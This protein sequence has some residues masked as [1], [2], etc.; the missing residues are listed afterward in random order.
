M[1]SGGYRAGAGR[2]KGTGPWGEKTKLMRIPVSLVGFVN[3][4]LATQELCLPYIALLTF[5]KSKASKNKVGQRDD[6][7]PLLVD[8]DGSTLLLCAKEAMGTKGHIHAH[9]VLLVD[10]NAKPESGQIIVAAIDGKI[11]VGRLKRQNNALS[12]YPVNSRPAS[13]EAKGNKD[14]KTI[15][16]VIKVIRSL[17]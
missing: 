10:R 12:F 5:K 13:V 17:A 3:K 15:G 9:D 1:P 11:T 6:I 16:V 4:T 8:Q 14:F 7:Y 2:P